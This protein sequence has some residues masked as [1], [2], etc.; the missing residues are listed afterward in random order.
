MRV[1]IA[2]NLKGI[3]YENLEQAFGSK[4]ELLLKSNPAYKK[5]PVLI[6]A[7]KPIC[8]SMIIIEYIDEARSA[9]GPS[10]LP[11]DLY[12]RAMARFWTTYLDDKVTTIFNHV[13]K[14]P[15]SR[16]IVE[17]TFNIFRHRMIKYVT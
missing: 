9:A 3:E 12:D 10:F 7:G 2:L 13:S 6:H 15:C 1:K 14:F 4:S 8:E 5:I 16:E 11:S 17:E